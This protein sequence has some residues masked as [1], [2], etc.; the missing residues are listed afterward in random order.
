[1][2]A[3]PKHGKPGRRRGAPRGVQNEKELEVVVRGL[4]E[5]R[6]LG[7]LDSEMSSMI[8]FFS[9]KGGWT[10]ATIRRRLDEMDPPPGKP[11]SNQ[12]YNRMMAEFCALNGLEWPKR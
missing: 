8:G 7:Q 9:E 2:V 3:H 11:M 4:K 6:R 1:M 12:E 10:V 5:M